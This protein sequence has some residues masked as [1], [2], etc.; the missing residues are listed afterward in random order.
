MD[1]VHDGQDALDYGLAENYDCMVLDV[2]MPKLN[3]I[4]VLRAGNIDTPVLL[5]TAYRAD[6]ARA[7]ET[8]GYGIGLS[9]AKAIVTRHRGRISNRYANGIITF[10]AAI[11]QAN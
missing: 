4:Q 1:V 2:M 5:L 7:R 8:G 3:G 6:S 11:P 9:T 10:S